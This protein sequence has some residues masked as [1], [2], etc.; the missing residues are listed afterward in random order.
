MSLL[1]EILEEVPHSLVLREKLS[2]LETENSLLK[3]ETAAL[4][5]DLREARARLERALAA[6]K[7]SEQFVELRGAL[8]KRRPSGGYHDAVYCP[9]CHQ[10][11]SPFP[12]GA[13]F[14]CA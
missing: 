1:T 11:A 12:P 3:D 2:A 7:Q 5:D 13:E 10:S 4:K 9:K 8:V 14:N 6:S